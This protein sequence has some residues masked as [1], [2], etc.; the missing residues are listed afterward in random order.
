MISRIAL[1]LPALALTVS[2]GAQAAT[3]MDADWAASA[4]QAWNGAGTL[5]AG[6]AGEEWAANNA[7]RGYKVI[8]LYRT[9]CGE[10]SRVELQISDKDGKAMCTYGGA[11]KTT[12]LD[13]KVDYLMNATDEDWACMGEGR[14]GCGAMGAMTTGKL[15]FKGPKMEAMGVM[16]P[17]DTFL[18]LTGKVA[19]DKSSCP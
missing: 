11:V 4:C 18:Q 16:G 19:G 1:A 14:L 2:A 9:K 5:T 7:G 13:P 8:Q 17:F 6:L 12:T 10:G 15:K 3:F